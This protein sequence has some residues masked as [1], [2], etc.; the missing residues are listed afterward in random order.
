MRTIQSDVNSCHGEGDDPRTEKQIA[1]YQRGQDIQRKALRDRRQWERYKAVLGEE[2]VP[3]YGGFRRMKQAGSEKWVQLRE[4]YGDAQ[5]EVQMYRKAKNS[6]V[7][8]QLP[9]R[10]SKKHVRA[11]AKEYGI[12]LKGIT[13]VIDADP[14]KLRDTFPN[15]GRADTVT[16][17]RID[18]FP[19]AFT[20]KEELTRTIYHEKIHVEQFREYG[21]EAVQNDR[22]RFEQ[23]AYDAE[24]AF[25]A[26]LRKEGLI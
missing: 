6:G 8:A 20:S 15:T 17:G 2:N 22:A 5:A 12:G 24:D 26:R 11:V 3:S 10:M 13:L 4:D 23:I 9:E 1:A 7:F 25:I 14:D 19:K 16:V 21:T 18:L